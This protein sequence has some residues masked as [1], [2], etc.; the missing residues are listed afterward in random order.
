MNW[1]DPE[2]VK[3]YK[4]KYYLERKEYYK[5][6]W[7]RYREK[8]KDKIDKKHKEWCQDNKEKIKGIRKNYRHKKKEKI[9]KRTKKYYLEHKE[10]INEHS[11]K[12]YQEHKEHCKEYNKKY[13]QNTPWLLSLQRAKQRCNNPNNN[14]YKYYGGK[15][16][17]C[18]LTTKE[19]KFLWDRDNASEMNQSS[20][21]RKNSDGNYI[22]DNCEFLEHKE[23]MKIHNN[24]K[25]D[26]PTY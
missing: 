12:Y 6:Y 20:I 9:K 3:E 21:H 17:K 15:G 4:K 13:K 10:E 2:E 19:I 16:I 5:E 24:K 8:H 22:I 23:H 7:K 26:L 25:R 14:S 11:K 18:L 1:T